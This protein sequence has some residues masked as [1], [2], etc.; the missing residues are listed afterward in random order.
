MKV[1]A[2]RRHV[3]KNHAQQNSKHSRLPLTF[4]SLY[5]KEEYLHGQTLASEPPHPVGNGAVPKGLKRS[6]RQAGH[7]VPSSA[8][9]KNEQSYNFTFPYAFMA[10]YREFLYQRVCKRAWI[11]A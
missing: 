10:W 6:E 9:V 5:T 11:R 3:V 1:E 4:W 7:A 2:D 8:V